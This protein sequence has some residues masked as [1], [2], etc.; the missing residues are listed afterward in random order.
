MKKLQRFLCAVLCIVMI[1]A[2]AVPMSA[3]ALITSAAP[4]TA[5]A[6]S[7]SVEEILNGFDKD[8]Y[9]VVKFGDGGKVSL[10][11][12]QGGT[13]IKAENTVYDGV[14]AIKLVAQDIAWATFAKSHIAF[15][16]NVPE[17]KN[18]GYMV[19]KYASESD[20]AYKLSVGGW[21]DGEGVAFDVPAGKT[22]WTTSEVLTV[23]EACAAVAT[24]KRSIVSTSSTA[25]TYIGDIVFFKNKADAEEYAKLAPVYLDPNGE[26]LLDRMQKREENWESIK[27]I[28]MLIGSAIGNRMDEKP[29]NAPLPLDGI[30]EENYYVVDCISGRNMSLMS[31]DNV[32]PT[33]EF[34]TYNGVDGVKLV[35]QS[36][37]AAYA[38]SNATFAKLTNLANY[39]YWL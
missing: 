8:E 30:K 16:N 27:F 37:W 10:A 19:V 15:S 39:N 3:S 5:A 22:G 34:V 18:Y 28:M 20:K 38:K 17:F 24:S 11:E 35:S 14:N 23:S 7:T 32:Q 6:S 1:A 29:V 31:F 25:D 26:K 2:M 4:T 21:G 9:A 13:G 12:Y 36:L 33:A